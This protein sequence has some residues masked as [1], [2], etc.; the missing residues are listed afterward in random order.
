VDVVV[1][2]LEEPGELTDLDLETGL[3]ADLASHRLCQVLRT[4][5]LSTRNRP[6]TPRRIL[7]APD[8]QQ[9]VVAH[10]DGADS[11]RGGRR[12]GSR[13]LIRRRLVHIDT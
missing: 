5:D 3:L 4:L 7:R 11:E 10:Y 8:H 2:D 9:F 6:E 13:V 1:D 12:R